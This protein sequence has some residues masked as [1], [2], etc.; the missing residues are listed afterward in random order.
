VF[1]GLDRLREEADARGVTMA[2]LAF[3]WVLASPGV[4]GAVCGPNRA[5]QLDPIFSARDLVLTPAD[6]DRV[7]SF[8]P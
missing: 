7:A 4:S 3:A 6:R 1:D 5:D 8:F 2:A